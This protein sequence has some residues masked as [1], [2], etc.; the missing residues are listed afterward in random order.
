VGGTIA[1]NQISFES[2]EPLPL[3][4]GLTLK[5]RLTWVLSDD[6]PGTFTDERSFNG[7]P[8]TLLETVT[9]HR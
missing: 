2:L 4:E 7:G 3:G 1:G 6:S 5:L 9:L 8:Y